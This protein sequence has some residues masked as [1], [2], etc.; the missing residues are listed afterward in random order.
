[1]EEISAKWLISNITIIIMEQQ[2]KKIAI[3]FEHFKVF[4]DIA[5]SG[6]VVVDARFDFSDLMYK[7]LNGVMAHDLALRIYKSKGPVEFNE[8][9]ME[10]LT[11][12]AQTTTPIFYDSFV[13]NVQS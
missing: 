4:K 13:E 8:K 1:M 9:E 6:S 2:E 11:A 5:H 3:D 10:M 12:F 7:N